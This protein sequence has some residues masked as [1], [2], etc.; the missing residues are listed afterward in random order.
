MPTKT[1]TRA[2]PRT[3][4]SA[5]GDAGAIADALAADIRAGHLGNGAWLKLVDLEARYAGTRANVRRALE[6]LA[7]KGIVQRIPD[8]GY[9]VTT[10]DETRHRELVDVRV[11]L[12][13]ATVPGIVEHATRADIA[14]LRRLANA[15]SATVR[16][17]DAASKYNANRA[18]HVCLTQLCPNR[19]LVRLTLEVRGNLPATPIAQWRSQ[20]HIERSAAEHQRMVKALAKRDAAGLALLLAQHIRQP[21]PG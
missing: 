2:R 1:T 8:R 10:V 12:E 19:E 18:F 20:A 6:Q 13:S 5:A 7:V 14:E 4:R 16:D 15:F 9:Y 21:E 3:A 11:V 17:G